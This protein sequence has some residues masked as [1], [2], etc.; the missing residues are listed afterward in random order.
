MRP[1]ASDVLVHKF[2]KSKRR[3]ER[4]SI[5]PRF[6]VRLL[7]KLSRDLLCWAIVALTVA[8]PLAGADDVEQ[9]TAHFWNRLLHRYKGYDSISFVPRPTPR[10]TPRPSPR[11][12]LLPTPK[13]EVD[14]FVR[15]E[16]D[17]RTE[18]G[19]D[20]EQL[21]APD[22]VCSERGPIQAVSFR[23]EN[24]RCDPSQNGQ[25]DEAFCED[26]GPIG[27]NEAV[28]VSCATPSGAPLL[29]EPR[30]VI[31]GGTFTVSNAGS[32]PD[33]IDCSFSD[34]IFGELQRN[35]IDT[36]GSVSLYLNDRFGAFTLVS[37]NEKTCLATLTY[38][39]DLTNTGTVDMDITVLDFNVNGQPFA[40][41]N[42]LPLRFLSPGQ[43]TSVQ[44][45]AEI[46]ICG[47]G[48]RFDAQVFVQADPPNGALCQARDR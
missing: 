18:T 15:V 43:S 13:A 45:K 19:L 5:D 34:A 30:S 6:F 24:N 26:T 35:I 32:L 20:C 21:R 47:G 46:D 1:Q 3:H 17:C 27:F 31:P 42:D 16:L 38:D 40:M 11:P 25:R 33:K 10:P 7:M 22:P 29:T 2:I 14:C 41:L 44:P 48:F 9:E 23:Y 36:S 28:I 12:T 8:D 39:V 4:Y 37:C